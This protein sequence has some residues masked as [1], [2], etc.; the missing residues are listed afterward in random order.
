MAQ[1]A[2]VVVFFQI[3]VDI[4]IVIFVD[5]AGRFSVEKITVEK[6]F[7]TCTVKGT[8]DIIIIIC[9]RCFAAAV[10]LIVL[11]TDFDAFDDF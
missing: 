3:I 1:I 11:N 10:E 2:E 9:P 8:Y 6:G 5:S 4:S 7:R